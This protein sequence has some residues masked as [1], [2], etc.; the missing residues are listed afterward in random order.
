MGDYEEAMRRRQNMKNVLEA[1]AMLMEQHRRNFG[2]HEATK[3][4]RSVVDRFDRFDGKNITNFLRVYVC[5][6][7]CKKI[8]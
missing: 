7:E 8:A 3:A 6:M 5:V 4:L 2:S 1:L